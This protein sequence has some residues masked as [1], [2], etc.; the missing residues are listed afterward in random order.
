MFR[1]VLAALALVCL[2]LF[3]WGRPATQDEPTSWPWTRFAATHCY[4]DRLAQTNYLEQ[5]KAQSKVH[6]VAPT[7]LTVGRNARGSKRHAWPG[8]SVFEADRRV[9]EHEWRMSSQAH[10]LDCSFRRGPQRLPY[11][12]LFP[13][14]FF[15][16]PARPRPV[17]YLLPGGRGNRTRWFLPELPAPHR[18]RWTGGLSVAER[19]EAWIR[20]HPGSPGPIVVAPENGGELR[21]MAAAV[22]F[23]HRELPQHIHDTYL[24]GLAPGSYPQGTVAVSSG[25]TE[26]LRALAHDPKLYDALALLSLH[27]GGRNGLDPDAHFGGAKGSRKFMAALAERAESGE[28][29]LSIATGGRD[30]YMPC[31]RRLQRRMEKRGVWGR[32]PVDNACLRDNRCRRS[33]P[34]FFL[35]GSYGH[36]Y[37]AVAASFADEL[38]WILDALDAKVSR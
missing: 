33:G 27:C 25:A 20:R 37:G 11:T 3:A 15:A 18:V 19:V 1:L 17:L 29:D 38:D 8:S 28:L 7:W 5:W 30:E 6:P 26:A 31:V 10:L 36:G 2:P 9:L 24:P 22:E 34:A 13:S 12:I 35:Y 14:D 32:G 21:T 4:V 23:L 16:S